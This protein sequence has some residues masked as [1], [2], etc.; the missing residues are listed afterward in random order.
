MGDQG[1]K[2]FIPLLSLSAHRMF[3]QWDTQVKKHSLLHWQDPWAWHGPWVYSFDWNIACAWLQKKW[4]LPL[5]SRVTEAAEF[6]K[7]THKE[8]QFWLQPSEKH[9][10][11]QVENLNKNQLKQQLAGYSSFQ[12]DMAASC[13]TQTHHWSLTMATSTGFCCCVRTQS[14]V[15]CRWHCPHRMAVLHIIEF[16]GTYLPGVSFF[17]D[18]G[19]TYLGNSLWGTCQVEQDDTLDFFYWTDSAGYL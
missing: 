5:Y 14:W 3:G 19:N 7:G 15:I 11:K 16:C 9:R 12:L 8:T 13:T 18:S 4:G 2:R 10:D 1:E 17:Q 6:W